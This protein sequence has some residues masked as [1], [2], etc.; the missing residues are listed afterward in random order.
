MGLFCSIGKLAWLYIL[1]FL[2]FYSSHLPEATFC[3][4]GFL[5]RS[6]WSPPTT[7]QHVL[8]APDQV[9][10]SKKAKKKEGLL[11]WLPSILLNKYAISLLC[12][13]LSSPLRCFLSILM[14]GN[15]QHPLKEFPI[16]HSVRDRWKTPKGERM[17]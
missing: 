1:L 14:E 8:Q 9:D 2:L 7:F 3:F 16:S 15:W 5:F 12:F 4:L 11:F 17:A 10:H 13:D 6:E